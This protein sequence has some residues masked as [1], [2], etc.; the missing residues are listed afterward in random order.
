MDERRGRPPAVQGSLPASV[1]HGARLLR[2]SRPRGPRAAGRTRAQ[3]R[4]PRL[5]LPPLLV[6]WPTPP[7]TPARQ[8]ARDRAARH[9][10]LL[11]VGERELDP[12]VGWARARSAS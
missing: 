1:T 9:S 7:R 2:P 8:P 4:R 11:L 5:L 10:V 6:R 12:A 3:V